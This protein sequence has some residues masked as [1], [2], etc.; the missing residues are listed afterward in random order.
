MGMTLT[1]AQFLF[2]AFA[3]PTRLRILNLLGDGEL[4]VCQI[5]YVLG[6]SQPKI[7]RHLAMLRKAGLVTD[8]KEGRWVHYSLSK[9]ITGL[10]AKLAG[11][12]RNDLGNIELL[13]DDVQ[14]LR[15]APKLSQ[16]S[17]ACCE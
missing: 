9:S 14:R 2:Q 13:Q 10:H 16:E 15:R 11:T 4:C 5:V 7:S 17:V 1:Q 8:H 12:V 6:M 3:D